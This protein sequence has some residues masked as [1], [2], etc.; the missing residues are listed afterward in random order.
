MNK[1]SDIGATTQEIMYTFRFGNSKATIQLTQQQLDHFPYLVALVTHADDFVSGKNEIGEYVLS[2][3]IRHKWF[4]TIFQSIITEHPSALFIELPQEANV[5]GLLQLYDYLCIDPLPIPLLK[6]KHLVRSNSNNITNEKTRIE[7]FRAKNLLE[8]RD[9]AVQF[10]IA[11]FRNEY[12]L[13]DSNTLH[14]IYSLIMTIL[15]NPN[16]FGLRLCHHTL[17][18]VKK[19]WFSLF[20]YKQQIKL[21]N[22]QES[23]QSIKTRSLTYLYDDHQP[24]PEHF[25]NAFAWQGI[26]VAIEENINADCDEKFNEEIIRDQYTSIYHLSEFMNRHIETLLADY[27]QLMVS[28]TEMLLCQP[29]KQHLWLS[30]YSPISES[31]LYE[32]LPVL[33]AHVLLIIGNSDDKDLYIY[34]LKQEQKKNEAKS[35]RSGRFN[36]LPKRPKIDKFKHRCGPKIQKYR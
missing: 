27:R 31:N 14:S 19:F 4:M 23:L 34:Q 22:A 3:R 29:P 35:A 33:R 18:L 5:L 12:N 2:S 32:L 30:L 13:D 28:Y 6:D 20:S 24:L 17:M 10:I 1:T 9:I 11:L 21:H 16:I 25:D 15:L 26:Y 36:T 7:Y 8:V